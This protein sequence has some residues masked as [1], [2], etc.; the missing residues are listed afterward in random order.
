MR[1]SLIAA[2]SI[3]PLAQNIC[4]QMEAICQEQRE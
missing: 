4:E 2:L 3:D 1:I